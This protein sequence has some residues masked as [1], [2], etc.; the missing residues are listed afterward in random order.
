MKI[1][2]LSRLQTQNL[3][4]FKLYYFGYLNFINYNFNLSTSK[5][6]VS[7]QALKITKVTI[8][9]FPVLTQFLIKF[10]YIFR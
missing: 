10:V 5:T 1:V 3:S 2:F 8:L 6:L 9:I 4:N 7:K